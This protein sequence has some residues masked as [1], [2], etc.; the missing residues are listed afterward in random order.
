MTGYIRIDSDGHTYFVHAKR[1]ER[2]DE[3]MKAMDDINTYTEEW[4][5]LNDQFVD[6]FSECM[7]GDISTMKFK[8]V[9]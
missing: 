9:V 3:L 7:V 1:I 4:D 8:E 6:E 5:N 2:F